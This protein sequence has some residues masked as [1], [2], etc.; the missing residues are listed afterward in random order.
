[1]FLGGAITFDPTKATETTSDGRL[2]ASEMEAGIVKTGPDA[3]KTITDATKIDFGGK[4]YTWAELKKAVEEAVNARWF[5]INSG[6]NLDPEEVQKQLSKL[7][8]RPVLSDELKK[9]ADAVKIA[10][11]ALLAAQENS[12]NAGDADRAAKEQTVEQKQQALIAAKDTLRQK[13][14]DAEQK[15]V[16]SSELE[17]FQ[18]VVDEALPQSN[19]AP[20]GQGQVDEN[21]G[22]GGGNNGGHKPNGNNGSQPRAQGQSGPGGGA[23][24]MG[25]F[26]GLGVDGGYN[27]STYAAGMYLDS[28]IS[29]GLGS[30]GQSRREGQ[31]LMMLFFYFARMAES[32]D[33]GA[34]YEL[35]KFVNYVI[36]KDKARQNIKISSKL[37][38]LQDL[39]RKATELLTQTPTDGDPNQVNE[40]T[41]AL[42]QAKS[43]EA[44]ISTSQKLLADMLQEFAHVVEALTNSTKF[45]LDAW[46]RV[47]R[48]VSGPG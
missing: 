42:H 33:L 48:R 39:S 41:K 3:T 11:E 23:G 26:P 37:I 35:I 21:G 29:D 16:A 20:R 6:E 36:A 14:F 13:I 31:K 43:Q 27:P 46:G 40:F 19:R 47:M 28:V 2:D 9:A 34:M 44:A 8:N 7:E 10:K 45:M 38:Q 1:M 18:S 5:S 30:I 4:T 12:K 22:R 17:D 24:G 25:G 15:G 32:G